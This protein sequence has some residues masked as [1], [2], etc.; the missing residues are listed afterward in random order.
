M[1]NNLKWS[2]Q[3]NSTVNQASWILGLIKRT[4]SSSNTVVFAK[5]YKALVRPI[6]QYASP[7]WSPY[8]VKEVKALEGI[9][10]RASRLALQ[11]KRGEML[12]EQRCK[13]LKWDTLEKR[14]AH[15][16]L[17][18]CYKTVF[19]LNDITFADIF[20]F[21]L[22]KNTQSKSQVYVIHQTSQNRLLQ[23]FFLCKNY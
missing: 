13:L 6:L 19:N 20:E 12:Y 14:R 5:L 23:T 18:E 8:Q 21:K 4:V 17:V 22:T 7:V 1:S 15:L 2:E 11:Q 9:Q 16:S 3:V 10:R